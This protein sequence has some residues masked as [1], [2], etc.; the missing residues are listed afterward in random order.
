L[1]STSPIPQQVP[2]HPPSAWTAPEHS[3]AGA[4]SGFTGV[5]GRPPRPVPPGLAVLQVRRPGLG[6]WWAAWLVAGF[7]SNAAGRL[8]TSSNPDVW[9]LLPVLDGVAAAALVVAAVLWART[10]REVSVAQRR[11]SAGAPAVWP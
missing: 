1:S 9:A 6:A 3:P 11:T 8:V 10:V 2:P 7:A 5:W 4:P